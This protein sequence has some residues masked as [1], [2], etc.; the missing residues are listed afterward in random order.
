MWPVILIAALRHVL[1]SATMRCK[2]GTAELRKVVA[3]SSKFTGPAWWSAN[4]RAHS[5]AT[6]VGWYGGVA[7]SSAD[8]ANSSGLSFCAAAD[9]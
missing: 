3:D 1:A 9:P 8:S 7:V 2:T 5:A 4:A 6:L